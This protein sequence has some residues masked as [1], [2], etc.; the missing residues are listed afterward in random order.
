MIKGSCGA[1]SR[2]VTKVIIRYC[3]SNW[4]PM[5]QP[6]Q[7]SNRLEN[8]DLKTLCRINWSRRGARSSYEAIKG[9]GG[10]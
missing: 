1:G 9:Q 3:I 8:I 5:G 2:D 6:G 10:D 7:K 4:W